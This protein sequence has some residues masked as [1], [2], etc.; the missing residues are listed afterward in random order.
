LKALRYRMRYFPLDTV[1][2]LLLESENNHRDA[3]KGEGG[4]TM[5][6][7]AAKKKKK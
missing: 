2:R 1:P 5:K 3:R 6:K 4:D 7:K